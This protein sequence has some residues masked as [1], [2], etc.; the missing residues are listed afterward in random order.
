VII[1]YVKWIHNFKKK[2]VTMKKLKIH[3]L[4]ALGII[5]VCCAS[6]TLTDA[7]LVPVPEIEQEK[8]NWCWAASM[9]AILEVYSTSVTQCQEANWLFSRSDCCLPGFCNST[10]SPG[11][12]QDILDN[13]GLSSELDYTSLTW[14]ELITEI[15]ADR[16]VSIGF[17]WCTGGGHSLVIAGFCELDGTPSTQLVLY[18]D[19]WFGEGYNL[20]DYDWVVGGCPDDH[21]W[22]RTIYEIQ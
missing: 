9:Q 20:A 12:Q 6:C 1:S 17:E 11:Q 4:A 13:W 15:D 2:E 18:M 7:G 5:M 21:E 14:N 22:Y 8:S 10:T 3:F 19:P 16:P